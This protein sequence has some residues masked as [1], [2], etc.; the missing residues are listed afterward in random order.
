[1]LFFFCYTCGIKTK[2]LIKCT[3][4]SFIGI[5][6]FGVAGNILVISSRGFPTNP[7]RLTLRIDL[8]VFRLK[9]NSPTALQNNPIGLSLNG[10]PQNVNFFPFLSL[11]FKK[12]PVVTF[13]ARV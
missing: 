2:I 8:S 6:S 9:A 4:R 3:E 10:W 12:F 1:L 13:T 5:I 11:V 7:A